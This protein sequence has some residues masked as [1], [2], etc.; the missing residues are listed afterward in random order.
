MYCIL[1]TVKECEA[2]RGRLPQRVYDEVLRGVAV[3]DCE[4]GSDRNYFAIGGFSVIGET[5]DDLL[6]VLEVFNFQAHR[7]EWSTQL[8]NSGFCS[9]LY[10]LDNERSV[11][12]Y[13]PTACA[14]KDII[15]N[16][17]D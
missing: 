11:M 15:E 17:E 3:L 6:Q 1:G 4:F 12:L 8:G 16:L 7:C 14:N 9:A 10:L 13:L 5:E 2:L